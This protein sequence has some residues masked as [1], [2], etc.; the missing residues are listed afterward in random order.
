VTN[1]ELIAHLQTLSP[2]AKVML[3]VH[4]KAI[5]IEKSQVYEALDLIYG[6]YISIDA[7]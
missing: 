5:G 3:F 1:E 6:H 4:D 2:N 7:T